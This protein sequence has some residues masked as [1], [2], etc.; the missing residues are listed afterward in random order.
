MRV[1]SMCRYYLTCKLSDPSLAHQ[2]LRYIH[3]GFPKASLI[4]A[5]A[6][7]V[8]IL[9][10]PLS[11]S[12][13]SL[14]LLLSFPPGAGSAE[15]EGKVRVLKAALVDFSVSRASLDDVFAKVVHDARGTGEGIDGEAA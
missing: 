2:L 7:S 6:G 8:L 10:P 1:L 11:F 5:V 15:E 4:R 13:T 9:L 3:T 12:L 14:F